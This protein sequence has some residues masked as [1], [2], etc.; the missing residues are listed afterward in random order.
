MLKKYFGALRLW[1]Y[2]IIEKSDLSH[3][4]YILRPSVINTDYT[5]S[6]F[7]FAD[8]IHRIPK[9]ITVFIQ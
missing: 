7:H 5:A 3:L 9:F 4:S 2:C 6:C 8:F 1:H